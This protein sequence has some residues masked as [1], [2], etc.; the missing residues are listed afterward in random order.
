[1]NLSGQSE[2]GELTCAGGSLDQSPFD[3]VLQPRLHVETLGAA[4]DGNDESRRCDV[5]L[6]EQ[7]V[8]QVRWPRVHV[9]SNILKKHEPSFSTGHQSRE[10]TKKSR[11]SCQRQNM[12]KYMRDE[13]NL[14]TKI[15][16]CFQ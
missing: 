9:H 8:S 7:K 16:L 6:V 2:T 4:G 14:G 15:A 13:S 3:S 11:V 10:V 5:P 1:M 12:F